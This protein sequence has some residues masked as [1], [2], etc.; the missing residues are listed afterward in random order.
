V[1]NKNY[2]E[3]MSFVLFTKYNKPD[4]IKDTETGGAHSA[5]GRGKKY[6]QK[7]SWKNRRD[8]ATWKTSSKIGG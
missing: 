3:R 1:A 4:E 8:D 7:F 6:T 5:Y 2:E